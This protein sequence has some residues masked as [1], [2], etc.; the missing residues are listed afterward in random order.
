MA[1]RRTQYRIVP[2]RE[3]RKDR[4]VIAPPLSVV[5]K[6]G[7]YRTTNWSFGGFLLEGCAERLRYGDPVTGSIGWEAQT[8]RFA[9]RVT[10][11]VAETG[12]L[13]VAIE[14]IDE[15]AIQFLNDRLRRYLT[16]ARGKA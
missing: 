16:S 9:G 4:R 5:L 10:R 11:L 14:E 2:Y 6:S 3:K 13:G 8:F 1:R 12:E 7:A 15:D